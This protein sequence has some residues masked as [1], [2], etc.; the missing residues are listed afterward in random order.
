METVIILLFV[1]VLAFFKYSNVIA[2]GKKKSSV[3]PNDIVMLKREFKQQYPHLKLGNPMTVTST[4]G[5]QLKVTFMASK[6]I[7]YETI[8][9]VAV[10]K[11][12]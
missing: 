10:K 12:S 1:F 8:S 11:I 4:E 7:S 9:R 3:Q 6:D 5:Q 2:N